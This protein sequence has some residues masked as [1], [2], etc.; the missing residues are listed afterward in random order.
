MRLIVLVVDMYFNWLSLKRKARKW[1]QL[2][3]A[4]GAVR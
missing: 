3:K 1:M 2:I 4:G